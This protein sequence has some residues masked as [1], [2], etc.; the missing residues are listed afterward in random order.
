MLRT[1][2]SLC[3]DVYVVVW[4]CHNEQHTLSRDLRHSHFWTTAVLGI[5]S[6][7]VRVCVCVCASHASMYSLMDVH[8]CR[9]VSVLVV[10]TCTCNFANVNNTECVSTSL[11]TSH[12]PVITRGD[13]HHP[14]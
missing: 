10:C 14:H 8:L 2:V 12:P 5:L 9:Y 3:A 11:M 13:G 4:C 6:R 1:A 7:C